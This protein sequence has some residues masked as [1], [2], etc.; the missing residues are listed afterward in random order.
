MTQYEILK[1]CYVPDEEMSKFIDAKYW[2]E[3]FPGKALKD[4]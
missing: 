3:Y 4:L 1:F 2:L